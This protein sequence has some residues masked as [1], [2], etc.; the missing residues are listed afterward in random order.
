MIQTEMKV[1]E[2]VALKPKNTDSTEIKTEL[3]Q[4]SFD[5]LLLLVT[6]VIF[7]IVTFLVILQVFTRYVT[8][9]I[10]VSFPW[11]EEV[12]RYLLI[13]VVFLGS[14]VASRRK[15]HIV[16]TALVERF[17]PKTKLILDFISTLL[18]LIFLTIAT[19][20]S[21]RLTFQ[22][23][24]TSVGSLSWLKLGHVYA[25]ITIGLALMMF[26]NVRWLIYYGVTVKK[27]FFGKGRR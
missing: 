25:L 13:V 8:V 19:I 20:G 9:Y 12:A 18:I 2:N 10:G 1:A 7:C 24:V 23:M 27:I 11:T 14:A 15:E 4:T 5:K 3:K 21:T 16:I 6:S 26:Y 17:S 22:M